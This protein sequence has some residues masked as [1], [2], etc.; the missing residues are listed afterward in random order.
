MGIQSFE[1]YE[2]GLGMGIE[3]I[4]ENG[5]E[6]SKSDQNLTHYHP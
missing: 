1:G 5:D 2:K 4:K 3:I 6:E